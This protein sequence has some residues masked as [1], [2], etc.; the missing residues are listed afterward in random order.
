MRLNRMLR[1]YAV[2]L[3]SEMKGLRN[4][5]MPCDLQGLR[6]RLK[7]KAPEQRSLRSGEGLAAKDATASRN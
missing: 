3:V 4:F 1:T 6:E 2:N 5:S 7:R